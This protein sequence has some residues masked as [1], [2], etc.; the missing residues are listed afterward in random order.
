MM[1][2]CL[3]TARRHLRAP[4]AVRHLN[5]PVVGIAPTPDGQGYWLVASDG[6]VFAFGGRGG[7]YGSMGGQPLNRSLFVGI[8]PTPDGHGYWL[9]ASDGWRVLIRRAPGFDG[10]MGGQRLNAPP[11]SP[12]RRERSRWLLARRL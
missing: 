11:W 4:W 5:A 9:V 8:A 12:W 7:F 1:G 2:G 3:P 6:G 10:S